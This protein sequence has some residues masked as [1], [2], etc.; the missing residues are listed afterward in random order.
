MDTKSHAMIQKTVFE[1]HHIILCKPLS[2]MNQSGRSVSYLCNYYA[3]DY[4]DVLVLSDDLDLDIGK[5]RIRY[6]GSA[7]GHNGLKSIIQSCKTDLFWRCKYGISRPEDKDIVAYVLSPL[8]RSEQD[9][10]ADK[11]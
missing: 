9:I 11:R 4:A 7:G 6:G 1:D 3:I 2:Y 8:S 5:V 10:F